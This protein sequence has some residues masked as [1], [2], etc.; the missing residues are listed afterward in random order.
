MNVLSRSLVRVTPAHFLQAAAVFVTSVPLLL[1]SPMTQAGSIFD[2]DYTPPKRARFLPP[3][4][5]IPWPAPTETPTP[6][7]A[8]RRL[9]RP[10]RRR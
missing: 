10:M 3:T 5:P 9:I 8:G 7:A 4:A 1:I 6:Y 2:D